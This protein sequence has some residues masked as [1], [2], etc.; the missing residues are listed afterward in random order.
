MKILAIGD[1]HGTFPKKFERLIKKEK[2]DLVVSNGDFFP[3]IYRDVWFTHCYRTDVN[4]WD[5]IGRKKYVALVKKDLKLGDRA[6]HALNKVPVPVITVVGNIDYTSL[7]DS[8][9]ERPPKEDLRRQDLLNPLLRNYKNIYRFDYS[10]FVFGNY[11]FIGAYG[12][13]SPGLVKSRH[14]KKYRKKLEVLFKRFKGK[15]IIFVSHNVPYNTKLDKIGRHAHVAV[16]GK[17]YGSKLIRRVIDRWQPLVHLGGHI[18]EGRGKQ[19]LGKTLCVNP[20]AAHEGQAA[21]I[22]LNAEK[23]KVTFI[24]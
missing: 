6:L 22:T 12:G 10:Y 21:V 19:T 23:V 2:I 9:D 13:S 1:F 15:K 4:L 3:F 14:Y 8:Y 16:R 24:N 17:H 7:Q 18:H 20:G 5:V 11:V